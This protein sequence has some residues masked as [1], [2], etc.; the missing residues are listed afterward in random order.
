MPI[1]VAINKIDKPDA[2]PS[3]VKTELLRHEIV[4]EDMGGEVIAVEVS[5]KERLNLDKLEAILLQAEV[6]DRRPIPTARPR[7]PVV[8]AK[9]DKGRGPVGDRAGREGHD[10]VGDIVVAG[11][12]WGRVRALVNDRGKTCSRPARPSRSRCWAFRAPEAGDEL[13]VVE[14]D[15]RA[16]EIADFRTRKRRAGAH[17][18]LRPR[19][20]GRPS[21]QDRRRREED[22]ARRH[23]GRR[24]G[25]GQAIAQALKGLATDEV[26][27]G[28][29]SRASAASP[30]RTSSAR[31]TL[32]AR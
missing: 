12:E 13:V 14:S 4:V 10:P 30:S 3:R 1:I 31:R 27:A 5:A 20:H 32:R 7:A 23:Q 18:H 26:G 24:A 17:R 19:D 29:S 11:G 6:L 16:R 25:L 15:A 2:N 28:A 8:E 22:P 21:S 9:L